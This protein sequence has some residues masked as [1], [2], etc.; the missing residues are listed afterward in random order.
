LTPADSTA[1]RRRLLR[2]AALLLLLPHATGTRAQAAF[3]HSHAAWTA[4]LSRHVRMAAD[5]K[6]SRVDYRG[7]AADRAALTAYLRTLSAV[8]AAEFRGWSKAQQYA[9]L[10]NTYN[11]FTIEKVLTRYPDLKSIRD[12]GR[13]IGN[14]WKD[15]FFVL[16]GKPQSLDGIEHETMRAAGVYDEPRVHVAVNCASIGCPLLASRALTADGLDA[17]LEDLM[18]RFLS[19]RSRNRYNPDTGRLELSMI[20][21]WYADDFRGGGRS[22]LGYAGF[23]AVVEVGARYAE[24]LADSAADRA[25]LRAQKAPVTFLEYDWRLNG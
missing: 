11:A 21:D 24:L 1:T 10:A 13:V 15:R 9:F 16:L 14:P 19:D 22:F 18:R 4:L 12:F 2:S 25:L 17:Q 20:F 5:G 6:S 7:F 23:S 3:D 8:E